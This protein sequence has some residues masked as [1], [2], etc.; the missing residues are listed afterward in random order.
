MRERRRLIYCERT[1][2]AIFS[3]VEPDYKPIPGGS[4]FC[5]DTSIPET[6]LIAEYLSSIKPFAMLS[7]DDKVRLV[8]L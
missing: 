2:K 6:A 4:Y 8:L 1:L 7:V 5:K 3:N